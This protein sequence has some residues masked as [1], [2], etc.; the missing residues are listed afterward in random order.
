VIT[1]ISRKESKTA[2]RVLSNNEGE[3]ILNTN[4]S[5]TNDKHADM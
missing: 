3:S 4:A 1:S 2:R 5:D